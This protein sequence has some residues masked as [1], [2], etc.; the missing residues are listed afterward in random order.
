MSRFEVDSARVAAASAAVNGSVGA[1]STEVD[2]MMRNLL[3]LQ[4][5]WRGTAAT[6]FQGLVTDWRGTQ[7]RVRQSLEDISRALQAA[8]QQYAEVEQ[9]NTRMFTR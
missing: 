4:N 2:R 5:S 3:D 6:Q 8:G 9:A 7:E 1:I